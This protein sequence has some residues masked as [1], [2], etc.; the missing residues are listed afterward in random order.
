[1]EQAV[2]GMGLILHLRLKTER[3]TRVVVVVAQNKLLAA[4][5]VLASLFS[6]TPTPSLSQTPAA[7]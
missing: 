2:V 3:P 4:Q 5:A 7:A 6:N 1:V